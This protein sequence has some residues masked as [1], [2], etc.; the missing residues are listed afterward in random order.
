MNGKN[1]NGHGNL[2]YGIWHGQIWFWQKQFQNTKLLFMDKRT[3]KVKTAI[4]DSDGGVLHTE[5]QGNI[6]QYNTE[7]GIQHKGEN[8][9]I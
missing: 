7:F 1:Q 8:L 4:V 3:S 9:C 6:E 2:I 5:K